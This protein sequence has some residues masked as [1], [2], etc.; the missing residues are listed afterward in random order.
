MI[1]IRHFLADGM[2]KTVLFRIGLALHMSLYTR[3]PYW[4]QLS[5]IVK[6]PLKPFPATHL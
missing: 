5:T 3:N 6:Y 2:H 1:E 4:P